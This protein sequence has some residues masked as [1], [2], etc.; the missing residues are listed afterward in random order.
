MFCGLFFNRTGT[1]EIELG[2]DEEGFIY[3]AFE[4]PEKNDSSEFIWSKD[5]EGPPDADRVQ[6]EEKGNKWVD[7]YTEKTNKEHNNH[8]EKREAKCFPLLS[9]HS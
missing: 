2:V 7:M 3:M 9:T 1:N 4:A 6:I 8:W 5:Y